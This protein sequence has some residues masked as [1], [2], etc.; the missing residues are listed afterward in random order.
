MGQ[1]TSN[2]QIRSEFI[3][4]S[5]YPQHNL[6][7]FNKNEELIDDEEPIYPTINSKSSYVTPK[8]NYF[9]FVYQWK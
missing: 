7:D 2:K 5:N 9:F 3:K 8:N 6:G 4:N 1:T